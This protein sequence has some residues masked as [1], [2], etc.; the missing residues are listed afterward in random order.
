MEW[1]VT[2]VYPK[3]FICIVTFQNAFAIVWNTSLDIGVVK[4]E[5]IHNFRFSVAVNG[6]LTDIQRSL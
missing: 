6:N 2:F 1:S 3:S 5:Y 4:F